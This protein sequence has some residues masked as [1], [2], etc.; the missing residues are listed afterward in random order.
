MFKTL[1]QTAWLVA[2]SALM[3]MATLPVADSAQA[4]SSIKIL[5]NDQPITT[6]DI[7]NRAKF[8]RLTSRGQAGAKQATDELIE[9]ALKLQEAKRRNVTVSQS[10]VDR[11]FASIASRAKLPPSKL[12]AALRQNGVNPDTLK[13][14]IR[15]ELAWRDVVRAR[16]RATVRITESDVAQAMLG[17]DDDAEASGTVTEYDVQPVLFIVP[18]KGKS[19]IAAQRK[20]E[21]EAFR[22]RFRNCDATLEQTRGMAGVFVKPTVRRESGDFP[23]SL[24][25][26]LSKAKVG[27]ALP[28]TQ[29]DEGFQVLGICNKK[30]VAGK[31]QAADEVR[32]ELTNERGQLLARRYLRDL[33][34][35]AIIEYR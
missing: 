3:A 23:D 34:S 15:A 13:D 22:S 30:A 5:V 9:E 26:S 6:Y 17:R 10:E 25:G 7:N 20:R 33:K 8:L 14:R 18:K 19:G 4:Q 1:T 12:E 27:T 31:T 28:P 29:V 32:D 24:Q 21:A 16:F 35:D 11:A 2:A